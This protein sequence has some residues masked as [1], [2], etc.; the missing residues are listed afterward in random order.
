MSMI[1]T[2]YTDLLM[3][4]EIERIE[5]QVCLTYFTGRKPP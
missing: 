5:K 1:V 4:L 2:T 3:N